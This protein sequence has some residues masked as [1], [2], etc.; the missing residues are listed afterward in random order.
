MS[1]SRFA[2]RSLSFP[3]GVNF[4]S[5]SALSSALVGYNMS[6]YCHQTFI[7]SKTIPGLSNL[8]CKQAANITCQEIK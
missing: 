7:T 1:R 3:V 6:L 2:A 4:A 8:L 5:L